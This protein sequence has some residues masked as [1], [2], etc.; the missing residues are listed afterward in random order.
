MIVDLSY[1][2]PRPRWEINL[3]L[4]KRAPRAEVHCMGNQPVQLQELPQAEVPP[5]W[6]I[7]QSLKELHWLETHGCWLGNH[8]AS[9][10]RGPQAEVPHIG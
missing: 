7:S 3:C 4:S 2:H 5:G 6:E 10:Q 1:S 9:L 8:P